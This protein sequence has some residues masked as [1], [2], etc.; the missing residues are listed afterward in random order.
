MRTI[1]TKLFSFNELSEEAKEN[2]IENQRNNEH[3]LDYEWWDFVYE[4]FHQKIKD[5]GFD[6]TNIYFRGF[7]SQGDGAMFEYDG[8]DSKLLDEAVDS[9]KLP[10]WKKAV[11]KNGYIS[12]KGRQSGHYCH[13]KSCSHNIYVESDNGMQYYDNIESLFDKHHTD[14]EDYIEEVYV[15]LCQELYSVLEKEYEWLMSDESISD[16]LI[17]NE[18]EFE[19]DGT[20][21]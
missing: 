16:H 2:A 4:D 20:R 6:I 19:E 14:I 21:Y 9:L 5:R 8:L 18:Y 7:W 1:E 17:A 3:Y 15:D 12:G 10:E 11:L 13:E